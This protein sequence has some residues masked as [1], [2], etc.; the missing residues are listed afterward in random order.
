MSH[1]S[2][3]VTRASSHAS[4]GDIE[5]TTVDIMSAKS[6]MFSMRELEIDL[7]LQ[8]DQLPSPFHIK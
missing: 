3:R 4:T 7:V 2:S 1:E 5:R 8:S 6:A